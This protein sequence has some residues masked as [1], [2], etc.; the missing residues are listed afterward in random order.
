M[1][2]RKNSL[3]AHDLNLVGEALIDIEKLDT[4]YIYAGSIHVMRPDGEVLAEVWWDS[5]SESW[6]VD[7]N[8]S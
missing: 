6:R 4:S 7:W 5:E 1:T 3:Y 2:D 8:R